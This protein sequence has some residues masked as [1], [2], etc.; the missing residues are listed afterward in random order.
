MAVAVKNNRDTSAAHAFD[1]LAVNIVAGV[2]C[3]LVGLGI[4]FPLLGWLWYFA[5]LTSSGWLA[6]QALASVVLAVVLAVVGGRVL[7]R[8]HMPGLKIGVTFGTLGV[9]LILLF[10]DWVGGHLDS[11]L[12]AQGMNYWVGVGLT[13]ALG[14]ALLVVGGMYFLTPATEKG[15]VRIGEQGWLSANSYKRS[16]GQRVRRG[17]ILGILLVAG[18]GI[19]S[20]HLALAKTGGDWVVNVPYTGKVVVTPA[21]VS[22]NVLLQ[23]RLEAAPGDAL[24]MN[25]YDVRD[26]NRQLVANYTK[27]APAFE[28]QA[29]YEDP[30]PDLQPKV[31]ELKVGAVIPKTEFDTQKTLW[32]QKRAAA[33]KEGKDASLVY[34]LKQADV[35]PAKTEPVASQGLVLLPAVMFTMPLLLSLLTLWLAWRL[36]NVPAFAD[37]LIATEA[38]LN[39]VSWTTRKRLVQDT[40]VVLATVILMAIALFVAD[41][42]W[43]QLMRGIGVLQ[44]PPNTTQQVQEVPW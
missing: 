11:A 23:Q 25:R 22:D 19:W 30:Y 40:V 27:V 36:V 42:V 21:T 17:T 4:A 18:A 20:L 32:E 14:I 26:L 8:R 12:Y 43:V 37:F 28:G 1:R 2:V 35:T 16:Q 5:G 41:N 33:E 31:E 29:S 34:P 13:A 15:L 6:L 39:K 3:A 38:E 44:P 7:A 24:R 10:T 9:L